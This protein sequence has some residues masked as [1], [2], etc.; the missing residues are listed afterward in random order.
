MFDQIP[1]KIIA[2]AICGRPVEARDGGRGRPKKQH[3]SCAKLS[4]SLGHL[5]KQIRALEAIT[6]ERRAQLAE[7]IRE[8]TN[9]AISTLAT[10]PNHDENP[11]ASPTGPTP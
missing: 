1:T 10:L 3:R 2:C 6:H 11:H 4:H 5:P 7:A 8:A 9:T